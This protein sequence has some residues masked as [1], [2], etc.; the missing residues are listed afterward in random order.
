M[1][2]TVPASVTVC[3]GSSVTCAQLGRKRAKTNPDALRIV[4]TRFMYR[5]PCGFTIWDVSGFLIHP[6]L[7]VLVLMLFSLRNVSMPWARGLATGGERP[8]PPRPRK[9][10]SHVPSDPGQRRVGWCWRLEA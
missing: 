4:V 10:R 8:K 3:A 5:S 7:Q 2:S 6:A 9:H 1:V